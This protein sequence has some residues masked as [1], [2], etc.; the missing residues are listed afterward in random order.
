MPVWKISPFFLFTKITSTNWV[1]LNLSSP[2]LLIRGLNWVIPLS[3]C[4]CLWLYLYVW[5]N[6][7][8]E[9]FQTIFNKKYQCLCADLQSDFIFSYNPSLQYGFLALIKFCQF[10]STVIFDISVGE[11]FNTTKRLAVVHAV[12]FVT[13]MS[14]F[15]SDKVFYTFYIM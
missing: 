1:L 5:H 2:M 3:T 10:P 4:T 9:F 7:T 8:I 13:K 11:L 15:L 14:H 12:G 6:D